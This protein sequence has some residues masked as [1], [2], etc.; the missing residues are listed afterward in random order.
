M[1]DR[2]RRICYVVEA[3]AAGVG[4][5]VG[6]LIERLSQR[7]VAEI[8]V[9]WSPTRADGR[10]IAQINQPGVR[11]HAIPMRRSLGP[12]D[13]TSLGAIRTYLKIHG[14]FDVIHGH[15]SKGGAL[16]RLAAIGTGSRVV[17]T[18]HAFA[19]MDPSCGRL[20]RLLYRR[21]ELH[22][23]RATDRILA[24]SPEERDFGVR[25]GI[26]SHK[27]AVVPN[28][29]EIEPLPTR[30]AARQKLGLDDKQVTVGFVGRLTSQK[31]PELLIES[32]SRVAE[33]FPHARLVVVG[34][35][36]LAPQVRSLVAQR[37]LTDRVILAGAL[38]GRAVMPAFD[39]LM[40]TSRYEGLSYV[41]LEALAAGLPMLVTNTTST[42][43]VIEEGV[44]GFVAPADAGALGERLGQ[45]M[46]DKALRSRMGSSAAA[47]AALFGVDQMV[48]GIW[49]IYQELC[50][51]RRTARVAVGA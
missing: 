32:F 29:I 18:P 40:M 42:R 11:G 14:P 22:L 37:G 36:P 30:Q 26:P 2:K 33:R 12:P 38:D 16:A 43:L 39:V 45:L 24:T 49:A 1:N 9:I 6:D 17:Y 4:R 41:T 7:E 25:L 20:T 47:K 28:A 51:P 3:A 15:S 34:D 35:G 46:A 50:S 44:N 21:L 8:H 19:A 48:D 10:F 13:L 5:H 27:L 31:N 23:A